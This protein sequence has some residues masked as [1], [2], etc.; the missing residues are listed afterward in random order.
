MVAPEIAAVWDDVQV[1]R[2][3]LS[4][5]EVVPP[6]DPGFAPVVVS[7]AAECIDVRTELAV[8]RATNH[9]VDDWLGDET[10]DRGTSNV[11]DLGL[12]ATERSED[13]CSLC[14]KLSGP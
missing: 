1:M 12:K 10:G 8:R 2:A 6:R 5:P 9:D 11:F 4:A 3:R 13:S 7:H 14:G